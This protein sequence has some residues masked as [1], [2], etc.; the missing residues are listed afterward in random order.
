MIY[1]M[2]KQILCR[3]LDHPLPISTVRI[4]FNMIVYMISALLFGKVSILNI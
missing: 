2:E 3:C 1:I 4:S